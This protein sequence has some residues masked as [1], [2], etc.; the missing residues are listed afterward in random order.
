MFAIVKLNYEFIVEAVDYVIVDLDL[1]FYEGKD[2]YRE[3]SDIQ[4]ELFEKIISD[5]QIMAW[6]PQHVAD[7]PLLCDHLRD[8]H[9]YVNKNWQSKPDWCKKLV[10]IL[11]QGAAGSLK[12]IHDA[13]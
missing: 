10:H 2:F 5:N 8:L 12:Q 1:P 3:V 9:E 11:E 7:E 13:E 4:V 6:L